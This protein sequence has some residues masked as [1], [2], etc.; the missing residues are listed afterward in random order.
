MEAYNELSDTFSYLLI[1]Q[2]RLLKQQTVDRKLSAERQAKQKAV[3]E[4]EA[5]FVTDSSNE[6][7]K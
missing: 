5:V 4:A 3:A 1:L 6:K 2:E 7:K